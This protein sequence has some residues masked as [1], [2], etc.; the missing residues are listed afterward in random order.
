[1]M[2]CFELCC[3]SRLQEVI[4]EQIFSTMGVLLLGHLSWTVAAEHRLELLELDPGLRDARERTEA[5]TRRCVFCM[6]LTETC[7]ATHCVTQRVANTRV[8]RV[9]HTNYTI[10]YTKLLAFM[11]TPFMRFLRVYFTQCLS[12]IYSLCPFIQSYLFYLFL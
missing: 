2:W 10:Q 12:I 7:N 4:V 6:H 9:S 8:L 3:Y 1:M 5:F 11:T